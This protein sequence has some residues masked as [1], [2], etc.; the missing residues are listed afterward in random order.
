MNEAAKDFKEG[1]R[2]GVLW[3]GLLPP[4]LA[5]LLQ[6]SV[7]YAFVPSLCWSGREWVLH[8]VALLALAVAVGAGLLSWRNFRAA[9]VK[10]EDDGGG[11]LPRTRLMAAVGILISG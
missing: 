8:L 11:V 1:A 7:S 4:P 10:W 9:G 3:A 5:A 2:P 6:Q